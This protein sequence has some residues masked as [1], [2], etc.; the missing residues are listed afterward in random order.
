MFAVL[1]FVVISFGIFLIWAELKSAESVFMSPFF[2]TSTIIHKVIV[3]CTDNLIICP[4]K[5]GPKEVHQM[6]QL[7]LY[8]ATQTT[9]PGGH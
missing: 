3:N 2:N 9:M 5:V 1:I 4:M 7:S 6:V 8:Q